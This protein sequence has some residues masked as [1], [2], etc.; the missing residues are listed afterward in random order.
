MKR[1]KTHPRQASALY[2]TLFSFF[3]LQNWKKKTSMQWRLLEVL[4]ESLPS[5]SESA[6]SLEKNWALLWTQTRPWPEAVLFRYR[7]TV[8]T[9]TV[10]L[11]TAGRS[12]ASQ[13][14]MFFFFNCWLFIHGFFYF[15]CTIHK[16]QNLW[17]KYIQKSKINPNVKT[18]VLCIQ[19]NQTGTCVA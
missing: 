16:C 15:N 11:L 5:K 7:S 14:K 10:L 13:K 8:T 19:S 17:N 4:P 1:K 2:H 3:C 6:K 18:T 12:Q 9:H